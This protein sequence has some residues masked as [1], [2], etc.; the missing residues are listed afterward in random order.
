MGRMWT[1]AIVLVS[2]GIKAGLNL[3]L[4]HRQRC[5]SPPRFHVPEDPL[6]L[7]VE[8]PRPDL[9]ADVGNTKGPVVGL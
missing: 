4:T 5:S 8:L 7:G 6:N 1:E 9:A 2:R 3:A